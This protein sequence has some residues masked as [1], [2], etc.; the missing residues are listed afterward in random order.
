MSV[1]IQTGLAHLIC[2][3]VN[4]GEVE[5]NVSLASDGLEHSMRGRI[6][7]NKGVIAKALDASVIG[8]LLTDQTLIGLQ[9][10]ELDRDGAALVTARI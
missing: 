7:A 4:V 3:G 5:Y 2:N 10:E 1:F 6:W 9:V 8:L